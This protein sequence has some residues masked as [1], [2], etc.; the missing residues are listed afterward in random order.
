MIFLL[1]FLSGFT[2]LLYEVVWQR[3]L[4][5]TFGLSTYAVTTVTASFMLGLAVGYF[6]AQ[7]P[8]LTRYHPLTIYGIAEG[9]IGAFALI[10]PLLTH[11]IEAVHVA[12]GGNFFLQAFLSF[13]ALVCPATLMGLTLPTLTRHL[14]HTGPAGR[15]IGLLYALNTTG[16]VLGAFF[17]GV[18]F[19]R[20]YGVF[21]TTLIATAINAGICAVALLQ[22][23]SRA[24]VYAAGDLSRIPPAALGFLVFPFLTGFIGL[25]LQVLW[26]RTLVCVVSNNTYSFSIVLTD[27]LAG[28]A[29]GAW[30]YAVCGP[31]RATPQSKAFVFFLV[32]TLTAVAI[33]CSLPLFNHLHDIALDLGRRIGTHHWLALGLVRL[34]AAAV[35][36]LVPAIASGFVVPLLLDLLRDRSPQSPA[37]A[38]SLVFAANTLGSMV[39][40]LSSGFVLIPLLGLSRGMLLAAG[41][42]MA[43]GLLLLLRYPLLGRLRLATSGL[44]AAGFVL[45]VALLPKELTLTKW[46]DRFE[47]QEGEL[48][49]YREGVFG[50]VAVFQVGEMKDLMINCIE[51]VPTHRDA[52]ATFKLLGHLPLLLQ[53]NPRTVLVNAVGG[54]ITLGAVAKH[55]VTIDAVDIVPDVRDAMALFSQENDQ[56]LARTNWRLIADDGRN[57][58]KLSPRRYDAITADATHPAAAESWVLYTREYYQLVRDKLTDR[59][60]FA[61]WLP[62]HNM[63]PTDYL[64]TLRTFQ[65]VFP[66]LLLLFT[67]RYTLMIGAKTPLEPTAEVLNRRLARVNEAVRADLHA[68][69]IGE[70]QDILKYIILDGPAIEKLVGDDYPILT[71]D[72][73]SVEFAELN[74]LGMA[75]TMP[76]VLARLLPHIR[77]GALAQR[78]GVEPRVF[79]ART[80][81]IRGKTVDTDDPLERTFHSLREV[82]RAAT[83]APQDKDIAYYQ[84]LTTVEFLDLLAARYSE[85]LHSSNPQVLLPKAALAAQLQPGNAFA[86]ELLGVTLLKLNRYEEALAP[87]ETAVSLKGDDITYLSNLAFAYD[88]VGRAAD[89]LHVLQRAKQLKPDAAR[90]LDEA[91]ERIERKIEGF[92]GRENPGEPAASLSR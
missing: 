53:D 25:A 68:L 18:F 28:L 83:L 79:L 19:I 29:L 4:H 88:Q 51:E 8:R 50:T 90:F 21:A 7:S 16:S 74:R 14:E 64:S 31:S 62:L 13:L 91:I 43:I 92:R 20:T 84:Q 42:C 48:L 89:A 54:G 49:F 57:F 70:G 45:S 3:L 82:T 11:A 10:F 75:G 9:G 63:A 55:E 41:V 80:L 33:V 77:P 73:T 34:G 5:L 22:P 65:S 71:D 2:A 6:L 12:A 60:I 1:F 67:N 17:G 69:G 30:L 46:Y 81:F 85:L 32:E 24:P 86:Q 78:Y 37:Q 15:R 58:L 59:G 38:T 26:V 44:L 72:H 36:T 56:V 61:Q 52:V 66:D 47:G 35:V 39:G 27:I 87:L 23:R 76:F 40:A